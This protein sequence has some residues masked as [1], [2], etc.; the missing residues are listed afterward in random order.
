MLTRKLTET[1]QKEIL[2]SLFMFSIVD[3]VII[4]DDGKVF[5][6]IYENQKFDLTTLAGILEYTRFMA[7]KRGYKKAQMDIRASLGIWD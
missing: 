3:G 7:E 6:S 2:A 4:D 5:Y 1:E